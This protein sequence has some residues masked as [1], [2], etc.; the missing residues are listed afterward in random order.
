[1]KR[2][3]CLAS[4]LFLGI[5]LFLAGGLHL[6]EDQKP[7][8]LEQCAQDGEEIVLQGTVS[9]REERPEY[10]MYDLTDVHIRLKEQFIEESKLLVYVEQISN[11]TT[12]KEQS[13]VVPVGS[14]IQVNGEIHFFEEARNPG[15]FDRKFYYRKQGIHAYVWADSCRIVEKKTADIR[16]YLTRFRIKWKAL[17]IECLGEEY[18]NCMSAILLGD[19]SELDKDIKN[20][21]QKSGIG[22]IL[23]ISG[24]KTQNL[25]IPLTRRTRINSAFMPLHIAKIYILKLCLD[26]EIIPRC[27]FPCSRG[28]F[29]KCINWQKKQ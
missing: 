8:P 18:G 3:L 27:R 2:P 22:H 23:A 28:Y 29:T 10:Q 13:D 16:E 26:E 5:W 21:Y 1:M 20:L 11:Q 17:L 14:R 12:E 4:V 6:A 15:N 25:A 19:K 9:K 7:S 24:V